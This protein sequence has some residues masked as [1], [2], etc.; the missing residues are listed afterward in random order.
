MPKEKKAESVKKKKSNYAD[1][2]Y[3]KRSTIILG[4][5]L[6]VFILGVALFLLN[7]WRNGV[8]VTDVFEK[9]RKAAIETPKEER[10]DTS[11]IEIE[12]T[13]NDFYYW[14]TELDNSYRISEDDEGYAAYDGCTI[15]IQGY[16]E[17][18]GAEGHEFYWLCRKMVADT[19][20]ITTNPVHGSGT[21]TTAVSETSGG[22]STTEE[23]KYVTLAITVESK[24]PMPEDGTWID[25]VGTVSVDNFGFAG[26]KDAKITVLPKEGKLV[27]A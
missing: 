25:A 4:V 8:H 15:H 9:N 7:A 16:V 20:V 6:L 13:D 22:A 12:V 3:K 26:I 24:T 11:S 23:V 10:L 14:T 1:E 21:T 5:I 27:V 2:N 19:S 18:K 17:K